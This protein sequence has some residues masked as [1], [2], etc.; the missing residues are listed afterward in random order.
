MEDKNKHVTVKKISEKDID[1]LTRYRLDYLE[2]LLGECT[3]EQRK[4]SGNDL[5]QYFAE[6]MKNGNIIALMAIEDEQILSFGAMIIKKIPGDFTKASLLE[7]DILNMYTIP[8]ARNRGLSTLIL[9]HL[10]QEARSM[11]ISKLS[12]H[13][14]K[15]GESLYRKAGFHEP[16]YP[17]LEL[18]TSRK[19]FT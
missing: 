18:E 13:T 1:L 5:Y 3:T 15:A 16:Q 14:T 11:G 8:T 2:E 19:F 10:I 6:A 4:K 9:Q 12:L 7:G 17:V